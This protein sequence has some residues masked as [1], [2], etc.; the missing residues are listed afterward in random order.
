MTIPDYI[1]TVDVTD[2]LSSCA[3]RVDTTSQGLIIYFPITDSIIFRCF[4]RPI[5]EIDS[6]VCFCCAAAFSR[7][8]SPHNN[9]HKSVAGDHVCSGERKPGYP[10]K[11]NTGA[12]VFYNGAWKFLFN[13]Y[14]HELDSAAM[15]GG[16]GFAQEM[17]I[18]EKR[19]IKT[20]RPLS[21]VN[22]YRAL[23]QIGEELCIIDS[24]ETVSFGAFI[25]RLLE[26]G[27]TEALY[28][29]M[30]DWH[31]SWYRNILGGEV[32]PIH[33]DHKESATNWLLFYHRK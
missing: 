1:T 6:L 10:C 19:P 32:I 5:P 24:K 12:V 16:S 21:D 33:A 8:D 18:H 3:V 31:Y 17:L 20:V 15:Y 26:K 11:N 2:S 9:N 29:D 14:S 27:V 4:D 23:C 25:N 13:T 28:L 7:T 30:G 22:Q